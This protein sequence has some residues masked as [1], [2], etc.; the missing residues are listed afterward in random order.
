MSDLK[1]I[2]SLDEFRQAFCETQE[3]AKVQI[4]NLGLFRIVQPSAE[5]IS[6]ILRRKRQLFDMMKVDSEDPDEVQRY[7]SEEEHS[8]T[9]QEEWAI[10]FKDAFTLDKLTDDEVKEWHV[11]AARMVALCVVDSDGELMFTE[12]FCRTWDGDMLAVHLDI[13][14]FIA[15]GK[16]PEKDGDPDQKN[17]GTDTTPST[18]GKSSSCAVASGSR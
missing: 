4:G 18:N 11:L 8:N 13:A 1:T 7:V 9:P 5:L 16:R 10:K 2:N 17:S 14:Y 3:E 6:P 15:T 12:E